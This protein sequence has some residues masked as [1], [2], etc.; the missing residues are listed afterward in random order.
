MNIL[1]ISGGVMHGNQD[2]AAAL[3]ID[4][5]L[6]FAQEEERFTRSMHAVG[7]LP[8]MAVTA[9]LSHTGLDIRDIDYLAFHTQYVNLQENLRRY[10][11]YNFGYCPPLRFVNHHFAHA[12]S[13]FYA[14]GFED[15]MILT[16]DLSGDGVSTTLC[17]GKGTEIHTLRRFEKPQ[18][19]GSSI[20]SLPKFSAFA[21]TM[22]NIRSW[23]STTSPASSFKIPPAF[24]V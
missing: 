19:L 20:P 3:L 10:F 23:V 4:G 16:A 17:Y 21:G 2:A 1:G 18:S 13:A 22:M 24:E 12:T 5:K 7:L 6:M 14:S 11:R 9:A 15:A 8:E